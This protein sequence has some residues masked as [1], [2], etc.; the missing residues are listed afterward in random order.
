MHFLVNFF[1]SGGDNFGP[2]CTKI[3]HRHLLAIFTAGELSQGISAAGFTSCLFLIAERVADNFRLQRESRILAAATAEIRAIW[4]T[5]LWFLAME[6][7]AHPDLQI[8]AL[9]SPTLGGHTSALPSAAEHN[10]KV[11]RTEAYHCQGSLCEINSPR[12]PVLFAFAFVVVILI[13]RTTT[14]RKCGM[15]FVPRCSLPRVS[16]NLAWVLVWNSLSVP[17]FP[18]F[19]CPDRRFHKFPCLRVDHTSHMHMW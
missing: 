5:Q 2:V 7:L 8:Q 10:P 3:A 9:W 4:C 18:G 12:Y 14:L 11:R 17:Y 1:Q 19:G 16:W 15:I 6:F 13:V